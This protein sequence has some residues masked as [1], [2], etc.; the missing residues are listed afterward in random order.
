MKRITTL[1][2]GFAMTASVFGSD[3]FPDR[4]ITLILPYSS[5]GTDVQYRKLAELAGK[6]LGQP[7]IVLNRP[8]GGGT[9]AVAQMARANTPDGYTIAAA[10]GPLLRQPHMMRVQ[11]DPL[12]DFTWIAGLGAYTFVVTVRGDSEFKTLP[13]LLSW[14]KANPGKLTYATPGFASSQYMAMANLT[15]AAGVEAVHVPFKGG[16]EVQAAV[17]GGHVVVG[18]NTLA[19]VMPAGDNTPGVRAL[20]SFDPQRSPDLPDLP[21][22]RDFG[23]DIIQDSPYGIV[24]PRGL[25]PEVVATLQEAFHKAVQSE[26]NIALLKT[27]R[28]R[29]AYVPSDAYA[30]WAAETFAFERKVVEALGLN[31]QETQ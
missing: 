6:E 26:E 29:A 3:T 31:H 15:R 19:G 1:L 8:G 18:V 13:A 17:L 2:L 11:F 23:F 27:L 12:K 22:V 21:V 7:I 24:G 4:P 9:A 5:G 10:T 20:A 25:K 28:Q 16:G 30:R 14:A